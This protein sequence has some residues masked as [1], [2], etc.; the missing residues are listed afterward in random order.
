MVVYGYETHV[1]LCCKI[2]FLTIKKQSAHF[3]LGVVQPCKTTEKL[4]DLSVKKM[5]NLRVCF[6]HIHWKQHHVHTVSIC[7]QCHVLPNNRTLTCRLDDLEPGNRRSRHRCLVVAV[8]MTQSSVRLLFAFFMLLSS[9]SHT[10]TPVECVSVWECVCVCLRPPW[11]PLLLLPPPPP[12]GKGGRLV[13]FFSL[14][15]VFLLFFDSNWS[16]TNV[17]FQ[18]VKTNRVTSEKKEKE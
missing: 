15:F 1:L 2:N 4:M 10:D 16:K 17:Y 8:E 12:P 7:Q 14:F 6:P 18:V 9:V 11:L 3:I 5:L 13:F